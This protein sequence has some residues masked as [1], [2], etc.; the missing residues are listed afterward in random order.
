MRTGPVVVLVALLAMV[1]A[2][3]A[4][5]ATAT[6]PSGI[7]GNVIRGPLSPVC[8]EGTPCTGPAGGVVLIVLRGGQ[9][10]AKTTTTAAG[11]YRFVLP[12]GT[13]VVRTLRTSMAGSL[14]PHTVRVRQARFTIANFEIDTGLR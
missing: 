14:Q 4:T 9:R 5:T 13:Y 8:R 12:P 1:V 3:G 10:I 6:A 11:T 2:V 7:R